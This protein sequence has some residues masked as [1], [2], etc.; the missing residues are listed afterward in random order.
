MDQAIAHNWSQEQYH[1]L[2]Y[3]WLEITMPAFRP[4]LVNARIDIRVMTAW[5]DRYQALVRG[6]PH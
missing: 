1:E 3:S 4:T 2:L 5:I 6:S